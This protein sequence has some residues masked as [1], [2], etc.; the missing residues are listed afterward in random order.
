MPADCRVNRVA[1]V[2]GDT[3]NVNPPA[4]ERVE[5]LYCRNTRVV[6]PATVSG[7]DGAVVLVAVGAILVASVQ[8][9][10]LPF[11]L[12]E[13]YVGSPLIGCDVTLRKGEEMGFFQHGSTIIVV[14][15]HRFRPDP[16][17]RLGDIVRVGQRLFLPALEDQGEAPASPRHRRLADGHSGASAADSTSK[18][19]PAT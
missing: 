11:A 5:R 6:I 12:D 14:L 8:L 16:S 4:L 17:V 18:D 13:T 2:P 19:A 15:P 1:F 7:T 10:F 9:S 3:W